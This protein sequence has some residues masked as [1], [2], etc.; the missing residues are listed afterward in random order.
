MATNPMQRKARNSFLLGMLL[1]LVIAGVVIGF[2]FM[3]LMEKNRKEQEQI[4]AS[5]KVYVLKQDVSSGQIITNDMLEVKTISSDLIPSNAFGNID[6]IDNYRLQDKEGNDVY[7]KDSKLYIQKDNREYEIKKEE[8]TDNYYI[9]RNNNKEYVELN[10]VPIVAKVTMKKNTVL[11]SELINKSDNPTTD[12]VRRVEYNMFVLPMDLQ[13]GDYIDVRIMFPSGQN[14]IVVSK[15]E[16][17]I[18]NI[19][20]ADSDDTI[21]LDLKEEEILNLSSA[22]V[23]AFQIKGSKLYVTKYKEA[24]MQE[25]AIPNYPANSEVMQEI[26]AN[27]NIVSQAKE[28]LVNRYNV[29]LRNEYI[30]SQV[31]AAGNEGKSNLQTKMDESATNSKST[32][33]EYLDS[34]S[35]LSVD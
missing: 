20:G 32:R 30:N 11:T 23:E 10:A 9:T 6:I 26:K 8:E 33:K 4:Q 21:W 28:E 19:G 22:I 12:D 27:P 7:T 24:G 13:T 15:K 18:P 2:L 3:Q 29:E 1:M 14:Y 17:E 25:A 35:E 16:V 5:K 34:L 31:N